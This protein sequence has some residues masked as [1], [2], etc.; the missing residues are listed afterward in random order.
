MNTTRYRLW[1]A[2]RYAERRAFALSSLG[3]R[4][5]RCGTTELLELDHIDP[6]SKEFNPMHQ[7]KMRFERWIVEVR[8]CQLLCESCH[9]KK[10]ATSRLARRKQTQ[11]AGA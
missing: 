11:S 1:A 7:Y 4:C 5:K 3:G 6:E 2:K 9:G 8:K 10:S